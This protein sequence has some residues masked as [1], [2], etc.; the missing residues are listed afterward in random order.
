MKILLTGGGGMV[1][2]NIRDHDQAG[3]HELIAPR[4]REL[5]LTDATAT[6]ASVARLKPDMIIHAAG[7]V[8]G[9]QANMAHPVEFLVENLDMGRNIVIAA[10]KAGVPRLINI[11]SSCMYPRAAPNPLEESAVLTG[12]LEPTN[13][14]YALAKVITARLCDYVSRSDPHLAYKTLIPC[15]IFGIHDKFDPA[16]SHLLPAIIRK[17]DEAKRSGAEMVDIWGSGEARREFMFASDLAEGIWIAVERFDDLPGMMNMG[18]GHDHSINDYYAAVA[19]V[20]G[21]QGSFTHDLSKP[22]GMKQKLVSVALQR[23]FGW[24]PA[25]PLDQAIAETHAHYRAQ[26]AAAEETHP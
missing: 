13:E 19:R 5:D 17:V 1:G 3:R 10:R 21:W 18:V 2:R 7:R 24:M 8:G 12:E 26:T 9:I 16:V 11:G 23:R 15:N 6:E 20:I 25:T 4:S 14:G 22:V